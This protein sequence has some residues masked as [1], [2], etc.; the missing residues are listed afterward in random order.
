[1][2]L[3]LSVPTQTTRCS[4]SP[5]AGDPI[6]SRRPPKSWIWPTCGPPRSARGVGGPVRLRGRRPEEGP[7]IGRRSVHSACAPSS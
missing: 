4:L 3:I 7:G 1:M 6:R 5:T 2:G